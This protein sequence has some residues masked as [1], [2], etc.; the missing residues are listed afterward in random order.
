M[1]NCAFSHYSRDGEARQDGG[2]LGRA[3]VESEVVIPSTTASKGNVWGPGGNST[4][5]EFKAGASSCTL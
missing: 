4:R 3:R 1:A 5:V 2:P